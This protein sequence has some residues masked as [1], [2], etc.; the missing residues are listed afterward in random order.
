VDNFKYTPLQLAIFKNQQSC[1]KIIE[2]KPLTEIEET[3]S[4]NTIKRTASGSSSGSSESSS[5]SITRRR[6]SSKNSRKNSGSRSKKFSKQ[7]SMQRAS[8]NSQQSFEFDAHRNLPLEF[9]R[10]G[11]VSNNASP[12][13]NEL[14]DEPSPLNFVSPMSVPLA[15]PPPP[16]EDEY[17]PTLH[18]TNITSIGQQKVMNTVNGTDT[19]G[20]ATPTITDKPRRKS[21]Q[22]KTSPLAATPTPT[23]TIFSTVTVVSSV[24]ALLGLATMYWVNRTRTKNE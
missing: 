1:I 23:T 14:D 7:R 4:T 9:Q 15:P 5:S 17:T 3:T 20:S 2:G 18:V 22:E 8:F 10:S 12:I 13:V 21:K 6:S 24:V 19:I 11:S 16:L